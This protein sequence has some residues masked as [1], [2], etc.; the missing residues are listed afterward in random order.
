MEI[1]AAAIFSVTHQDLGL[2]RKLAMWVPMLLW[3]NQKQER[4]RI[5]SEFVAVTHCNSKG[6]LNSISTMD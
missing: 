6:M 4:I 1:L 2:E 5:Y 3:E